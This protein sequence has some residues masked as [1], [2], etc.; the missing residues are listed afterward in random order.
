MLM[1]GVPHGIDLKE[2]ET[3]LTSIPGVRELHDLHVWS[4][5]SDRNILSVHV[6]V[7]FSR[8]SLDEVVRDVKT[9]A[10]AFGIHHC[11]VQVESQK[12]ATE[13]C[14]EGGLEGDE[15]HSHGSTEDR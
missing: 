5:T 10:D 3:S 14:E 15:A 11:T 1:Q 4:V 7:D 6:I 12:C 8:Q 2:V 9:K 13:P